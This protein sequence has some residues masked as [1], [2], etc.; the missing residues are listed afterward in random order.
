[1]AQHHALGRIAQRGAVE[2]A[3]REP[4]AFEIDFHSPRLA[5]HRGGVLGV[6]LGD[7][8]RLT[9]RSRSAPLVGIAVCRRPWRSARSASITSPRM[10]RAM[11]PFASSGR[12]KPATTSLSRMA[13]I[14]VPP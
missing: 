12:M 1:M 9:V 7:A 2:V 8:D 14:G 4:H 5:I 6:F 3:R 10:S 11:A 13:S